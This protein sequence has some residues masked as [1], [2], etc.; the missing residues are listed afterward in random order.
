MTSL[1]IVVRGGERVEEF[2]ANTEISGW[3]VLF[4][5]ETRRTVAL[6]DEIAALGHTG[7]V[8]TMNSR[9]VV[10]RKAD[11]RQVHLPNIKLLEGP[12]ANHT[13]LGGRRSELAVKL[14]GSIDIDTVRAP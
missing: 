11:G 12:V 13:V 8:E 1:A 7:V 9:S 2:I 5:V 10:I 14:T 4:A 3:D 6:G